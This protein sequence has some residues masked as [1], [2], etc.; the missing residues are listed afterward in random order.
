MTDANIVVRTTH[1]K[2]RMYRRSHLRTALQTLLKQRAA[3]AKLRKQTERAMS[4]GVKK[5]DAALEGC[6][7]ASF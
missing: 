6:R 3:E 7:D 4:R 5:I 2:V 1:R